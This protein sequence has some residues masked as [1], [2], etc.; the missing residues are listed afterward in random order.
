LGVYEYDAQSIDKRLASNQEIENS[1][2]EAVCVGDKLK[3]VEAE[4][5]SPKHGASYAPALAE[6]NG[7]HSLDYLGIAEIDFMP[8]QS[9]TDGLGKKC[10]LNYDAD[11]FG[12]EVS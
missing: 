11:L 1:R 3:Q 9:P 8:A 10:G 5:N 7:F 4:G 2:M 6:G 12:R